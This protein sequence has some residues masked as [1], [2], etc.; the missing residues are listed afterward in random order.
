MDRFCD[1]NELGRIAGLVDEMVPKGFAKYSEDPRIIV[2]VYFV[3]IF[4]WT[5][6]YNVDFITEKWRTVRHTRKLGII[7]LLIALLPMPFVLIYAIL[8]FISK[9]Y[10]EMMTAVVGIFVSLYHVTRTAWGLMQLDVFRKW[11]H[12]LLQRM[13]KMDMIPEKQWKHIGGK[14]LEIFDWA[15]LMDKKDEILRVNNSI[16]DNELWGTDL[17]VMIPLKKLRFSNPSFWMRT[18]Q[19]EL[20]TIRWSAAVLATK[21]GEFWHNM[22][23]ENEEP[24]DTEKLFKKCPKSLNCLQH[25]TFPV[26]GRNIN[27]MFRS[28]DWEENGPYSSRLELDEA[29]SRHKWLKNRKRE[30]ETIVSEFPGGNERQENINSK[31]E[32]VWALNYAQCMSE[33]T[34]NSIINYN[35]NLSVPN[36]DFGWNLLLWQNREETVESSAIPPFPWGH[37]MVPLWDTDT[38]W[39]V[40]QA[41]VHVDNT[42]TANV[43][44]I[45]QLVTDPK[46]AFGSAIEKTRHLLNISDSIYSGSIAEMVRTFLASWISKSTNISTINWQP[47]LPTK[48]YKFEIDDFGNEKKIIAEKNMWR[49]IC[50]SKLQNEISQMVKGDVN[51]PDSVELILLFVLAFPGEIYEINNSEQVDEI[52]EE[53]EDGTSASK[54]NPRVTLKIEEPV[55]TMT[56]LEFNAVICPEDIR[57]QIKICSNKNNGKN[58]IHMRLLS[59]SARHFIWEDWINYLM[60]YIKGIDEL[61]VLGSERNRRTPYPVDLMKPILPISKSK[62]KSIPGNISVWTGWPVFDVKIAQFE[63]NE[64]MLATGYLDESY[65]FVSQSNCLWNENF[66]LNIR[67]AE[68]ELLRILKMEITNRPSR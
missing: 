46:D 18:K 28:L 5:I 39:R 7:Q 55:T 32:H 1:C 58:T 30:L 67:K 25:V 43:N 49:W 65:H 53:N 42:V 66:Q 45:M 20:C 37:L 41:T 35:S 34:F 9:D 13:E 31:I 12:G 38:N 24:L 22:K 54:L 15:G 57:V 68:N 56:Q 4:P 50:Q 8:Q 23:K 17:G 51:L 21:L 64:W 29:G 2:F 59:D 26:N 52:M 33:D 60:G 44:P 48:E 27:R 16:V 11:T 62:Y 40:L 61:K 6:L 3:V 47:R 36:K 19:A 14:K 10:K 63:M